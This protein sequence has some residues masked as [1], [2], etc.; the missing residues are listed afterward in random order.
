MDRPVALSIGGSDSSGCAG[1]QMDVRTFSRLGAYGATAVTAVTAQSPS[2]VLQVT[3]LSAEAV[4]LQL[5]AVLGE[6]PVAAAKTGMLWSAEIVGVV[7]RA[8]SSPGFP[9]LV[10]DP[11]LASSSGTPLLQPDALE[12]LSNDLLPRSVLCTPNLAEAARLLGGPPIETPS[13]MREA[14]EALCARHGC[15]VLVKGGHLPGDPVD[16]LYDGETVHTWP[17]DRATGVTP[18][19]TGCMLSAAITA[20][21]ALGA[22]LLRACRRA[23]SFVSGALKQPIRLAGGLAL[24][25]V[26]G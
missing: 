5:K 10:V 22:P 24:P 13:A 11:V 25:G 23:V 6:L 3:P 4:R 26:E 16:L 18:R 14:A 21:L 17:H 12:R 8:A 2:R 20:H 15:A 1:V 19:G 9:R 7:A